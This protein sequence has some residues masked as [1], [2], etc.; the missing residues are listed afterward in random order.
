MGAAAKVKESNARIRRESVDEVL[1][2]ISTGRLKATERDGMMWD[3]A[4]GGPTVAHNATYVVLGVVLI[5]FGWCGFNGGSA[6]APNVVAASSLANTNLAAGF[7]MLA[8]MQFEVWCG[9]NPSAVGAATGAVCGLV[10]VTPCAGY[11]PALCAPPVGMLSAAVSFLVV[12]ADVFHKYFDWL[13]NPQVL[14]LTSCE[15]VSSADIPSQPP[16][17]PMLAP[18]D[19]MATHGVSGFV[20]TLLTGIFAYKPVNMDE[21]KLTGNGLLFGGGVAMFCE[22]TFTATMVSLYGNVFQLRH[23]ILFTVNTVSKHINA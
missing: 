20:G 2:S 17:L 12:Y 18:Q 19:V 13:D 7:G 22:E 14:P 4:L 3:R 23:T 10:G 11:I 9:G 6:Y 21:P 5:W 15:S 16:L 8:W 1:A